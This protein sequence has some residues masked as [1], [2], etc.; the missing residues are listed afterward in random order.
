MQARENK[1]AANRATKLRLTNQSRYTPSA[2][3]TASK[4]SGSKKPWQSE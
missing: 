3:K 2:T 1:E 4:G